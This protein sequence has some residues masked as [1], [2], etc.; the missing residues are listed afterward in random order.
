MAVSK[1]RSNGSGYDDEEQRAD[2][3]IRRNEEGRARILGAPHVNEGEDGKNQQAESEGVWLKFRKGRDQRAHARRD[4]HGG[5]QNVVD[6]EGRGREKTGGFSK[7]LCSDGIT[8]AA[9]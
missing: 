7:I 6:H 4:T 3:Q 2:E 8:A 1:N 5:V 9:M